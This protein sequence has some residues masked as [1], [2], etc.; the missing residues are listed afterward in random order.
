MRAVV[1]GADGF[2]GRHL[3]HH[4]RNS[5]DTVIEGAGPH[6]TSARSPLDVRDAAAVERFIHDATPDAVYHLA[7]VAYGPDAARDLPG[8]IAINVGGTANVLAA[9]STLASRPIVLVTG[10]SE[11]YGAPDVDRINEAAPLRPA[12]L[13]GATKVAQETLALTYGRVHGLP[14]IVTRSF[15]HIGPGQRNSFAVASFAAQLQA[16][17]AGAAEPR[18]RVGNLDPVRDFTDVRD[19]VRA[20]RMLTVDGHAGEALNVASG[21]GRAMRAIVDGLLAVSGLSVRIE[22]DPT[23]VRTGDPPRIVGDASRLQKLTGWAPTIP[24]DQTL[25]D[26]WESVSP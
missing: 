13:Y 14:V 18:L 21:Q 1:V 19:V 26:V 4:L 7:A 5:G 22:S 3:V 2:V 11:V 6:A 12:S 10:S 25:R 20:Y 24:L 8:A 23:R 9:A 17:K 15:N 16:I